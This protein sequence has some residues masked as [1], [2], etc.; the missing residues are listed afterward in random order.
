MTK[1]RKTQITRHLAEEDLDRA[2]RTA[3]AEEDVYLLQRLCFVKNCYHG[4]VVAT[5]ASRVGASQ[6]AGNRWLNNWNEEGLDGLRPSFAGGRPPKLSA[7]Q[8]SELA[9]LLQNDEPWTY[10]Q[11]QTMIS[12]RFGVEYSRAYLP[13]LLEDVDFSVAMRPE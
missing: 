6:S 13:R 9:S 2:I 11:I 7:E 5:A 4:D 1:G 10:A 3:K 8:R 12:R